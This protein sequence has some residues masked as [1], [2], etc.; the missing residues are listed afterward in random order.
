MIDLHTHLLPGVDDGARTLARALAVLERAAAAGVR[1]V[2]CTPHLRSSALRRGAP[3]RHEAL[4]AALAEGA[5][6]GV[7]VLHGWEIML[8]EPAVALTDRSLAIGDSG[9]VL[10]EWPRGPALPPNGVAELARIRASGVVPVL[11]H[12]ERYPGASPAQARAWRDAGA[13]LQGDATLFRAP[14]TRGAAA[15]ALLAAGALDL[16][17]SD[18]HGDGRTL[19]AAREALTAAGAAEAALLLTEVNPERILRGLPPH[20]VPPVADEPGRWARIARF[21]TRLRERPRGDRA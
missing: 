4:L 3:A 1:V 8:D 14:G 5:P 15:R 9:A 20:P 18:N 19:A 21:V 10:V 7:T 11:A 17:A 6:A 16:L 13:V 12:P 2:A